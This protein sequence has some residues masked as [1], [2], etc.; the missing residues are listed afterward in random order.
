MKREF[1]SFVLL[2][3]AVASKEQTVS[4]NSSYFVEAYDANGNAFT[5]KKNPDAEGSPMFFDGW[6]KGQVRFKNGFLL[7]EVDLQFNLQYNSPYFRKDSIMYAFVDPIQEFRLFFKT[8]EGDTVFLFRCGYPE[9]GFNSPASFYQVLADG[10]NFQLLKYVTKSAQ[11]NYQYGQAA[12]KIYKQAE[13]L[14]AYD[15][16]R[17]R[18]VKVRKDRGA[19]ADAITEHSKTITRFAEEKKYK[20]KSEKEIIELFNLLNQ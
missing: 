10:N 2:F 7:K 13:Q 14:Y 20:M 15:I 4:Y 11:E 12:R 8:K 6:T 18:I 9:T 5:S 17:N 19:L 1:L 3:I 16:K